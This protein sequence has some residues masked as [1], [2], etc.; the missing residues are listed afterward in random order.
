[1]PNPIQDWYVLFHNHTEGMALYQY[2]RKQGVTVK[3]SPTP[4]A[5]SVCCGMSLLV[6]ENEREAVEACLRESGLAYDRFL[7]LPRQIDAK[8]DRFV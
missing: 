2:I 4:R 3:I 8:R 7:S 6:E 5:A 1:M